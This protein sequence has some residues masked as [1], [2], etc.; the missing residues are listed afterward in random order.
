VSQNF[1]WL[2]GKLDVLDWV[3]TDWWGTPVVTYGD[4]SALQT[5][6]TVAPTVLA[7]GEAATGAERTLRVTVHNGG[8]APA[9]L[10]R[11]RVL[12]GA[13]GDEVLPSWWSDNYVSLMPGERRELTVRFAAAVLGGQA[14]VVAL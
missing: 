4:L 3:K 6:P 13:G 11:L 14:P 7:S 5:L 9:L 12:R 8:K 1:Y 10:V 2:P